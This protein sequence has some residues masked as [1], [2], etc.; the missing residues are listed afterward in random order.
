[1][2]PTCP[3][4]TVLHHIRPWPRSLRELARGD[5]P[6]WGTD[7]NGA[8]GT[9]N[10]GTLQPRYYYDVTLG[11][12]VSNEMVFQQIG[13]PVIEAVANQGLNGTVFAYGVTSSGKTHTMMVSGSLGT[14]GS[15]A[16]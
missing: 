16:L 4:T 11:E 12:R 9:W 2:I 13:Q 7:G 5:F 14:G 6:V 3:P 15:D 1:M 10:Q 8:V